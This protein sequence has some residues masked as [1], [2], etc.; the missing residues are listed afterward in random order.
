MDF[1]WDSAN[2]DLS[3][4]RNQHPK[5]SFDCSEYFLLFAFIAATWD[6]SIFF[7]QWGKGGLTKASVSSKESKCGGTDLMNGWL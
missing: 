7:R 2:R 3:N 6:G 5:V 4:N 1:H